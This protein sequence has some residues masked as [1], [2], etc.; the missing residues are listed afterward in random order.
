MR[1]WYVVPVNGRGQLQRVEQEQPE[2]GAGEVLVKIHA[3][4]LNHRDLYIYNGR[5]D[6]ATDAPIIPLSDGAG[7]IVALGE[8]SGRFQVGEHVMLPFFP[9][10][11]N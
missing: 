1:S 2:P 8:G 4:S 3:A 10:L 5:D 9:N 6:E 11:L 7:E